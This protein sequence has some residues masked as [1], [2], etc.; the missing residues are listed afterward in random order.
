MKGGDAHGHSLV[1]RLVE[2]FSHFRYVSRVTSVFRGHTQPLSQE[3]GHRTQEQDAGAEREVCEF[4]TRNVTFV[5]A[6]DRVPGLAARI[7]TT[8]GGCNPSP[9][10]VPQPHRGAAWVRVRDRV[11]YTPAGGHARRHGRRA[12]DVR[13]CA[14][15]RTTQTR[16][17]SVTLDPDLNA[18]LPA[19][20]NPPCPPHTYRSYP[21]LQSLISQQRFARAPCSTARAHRY[22][23]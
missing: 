14:T 9:P 10:S 19:L 13:Y 17:S 7:G 23:S 8:P 1:E 2:S 5:T 12:R 3:H 21:I 6:R 22:P 15:R 18:V 16:T 11:P 20:C 4:K